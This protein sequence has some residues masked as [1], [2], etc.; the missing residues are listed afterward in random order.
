MNDPVIIPGSIFIGETTWGATSPISSPAVFNSGPF[1]VGSFM[2]VYTSSIEFK[3][4]N[5]I[6]YEGTGFPPD[7]YVP[8][9][10]NKLYSGIDLQLQ[11]AIKLF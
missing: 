5:D 6:I 7:T 3:Y 2:N 4:I 1:K 10:Q 8:F 9:D 11:K